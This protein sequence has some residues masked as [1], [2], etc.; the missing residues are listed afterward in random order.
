MIDHFFI[1]TG[2]INAPPGALPR[3]IP[4][5]SDAKPTDTAEPA[6]DL[7]ASETAT[8]WTVDTNDPL[9]PPPPEEFPFK[10]TNELHISSLNTTNTS[11][12]PTQDDATAETKNTNEKHSVDSESSI[13]VEED[14]LAILVRESSDAENRIRT[15]PP[16]LLDDADNELPTLA[17]VLTNLHQRYYEAK[18]EAENLGIADVKV[19]EILLIRFMV[20]KASNFHTF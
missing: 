17:V 3:P 5:P 15:H 20:F 10:E 16:F 11:T 14:P 2:D 19:L 7:A 18:G 13:P 8:S 12:L 6:P 4:Q 9:P 1:G